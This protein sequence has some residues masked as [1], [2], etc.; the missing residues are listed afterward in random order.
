MYTIIGGDGKEYGP[1][2]GGD[3]RKWISEERLNAQSLAKAESDAEFRPLA[4]FPEFPE[5][6]RREAEHLDARGNG[7]TEKNRRKEQSPPPNEP[8]SLSRVFA[9]TRG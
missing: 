9:T 4:A 3:L 5:D 2:S 7:Q 6:D 1:I 8:A